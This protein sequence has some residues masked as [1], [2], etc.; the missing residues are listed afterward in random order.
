MHRPVRNIIK[1]EWFMAKQKKGSTDKLPENFLQ[2]LHS[3]DCNRIKDIFKTC[4]LEATFRSG[5]TAVFYSRHMPED[6]M[7]WLVEQGADINA[8][9][10]WGWT[11]LHDILSFA[12]DRTDD[13]ELLLYLGADIHA[14]TPEGD[15]PLHYAAEWGQLRVVKMLIEKGADAYARNEEGETPMEYML[16]EANNSRIRQILPVAEYF[17]SLGVPVTD[18]AVESL[19]KLATG[20][21]FHRESFNP[22]KLAE[23]EEALGAL[24]K[25]FDVQEA[26]PKRSYDGKEKI[27]AAP[28]SWQEQ[29]KELYLW[30]VSPSAKKA[31]TVQ[32]ELLRLSEIMYTHIREFH[33]TEWAEFDTRIMLHTFL[34]YLRMGN[35]LSGEERKE[36]KF[37]IREMIRG[38]KNLRPEKLC[39]LTVCWITK[40]PDPI[41]LGKTF[42]RL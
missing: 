42:Y 4:S 38:E 28:G 31:G 17:L 2:I 7:W 9:N 32:E 41:P 15:T 26:Q 23:T 36:A 29:Y 8:R 14:V 39:E 10:Q 18:S 35:P 19:K 1:G 21:A 40:N 20:F 6:I 24:L 30:I 25:L 27:I 13:A 5:Q 37:V 16:A 34:H 22:E 12:Q 3:G 11:P 33:A